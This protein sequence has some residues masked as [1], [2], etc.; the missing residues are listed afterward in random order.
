[1]SST[2]K[3]SIGPLVLQTAVAIVLSAIVY[4]VVATLMGMFIAAI[5]LLIS[6]WGPNAIRLFALSF[7]AIAGV[8]SAR[9]ACD[10]ALRDYSWKTVCIV[11]VVVNVVVI[12]MAIV[13][14]PN[15]WEKVNAIAQPLVSIFA[16]VEFFWLDKARSSADY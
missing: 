3:P 14:L 5:H 1:M 6:D 9:A 12:G 16:A 13:L 2:A 4:M 11:F 10:L 15:E 8:Y 7:G